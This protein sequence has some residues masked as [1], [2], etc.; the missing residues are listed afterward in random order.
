[1]GIDHVWSSILERLNQTQ[2]AMVADFNPGC[3]PTEIEALEQQIGKPVPP[4]F[5]A[6]YFLHNGQKGQF[7]G[8]FRLPKQS[9]EM[10]L[11]LVN[12]CRWLSL[13]EIETLYKAL[14]VDR[15]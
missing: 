5:R 13:K 1:M 4:S 10:A 8:L 2:P 12:G 11:G 7:G 15:D 6:W 3:T 9:F 14:A